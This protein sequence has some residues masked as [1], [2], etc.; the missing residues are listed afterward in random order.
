MP[1]LK[2]DSEGQ[3]LSEYVGREQT[4]EGA[5]MP[6]LSYFVAVKPLTVPY[7]QF[8]VPINVPPSRVGVGEK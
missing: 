8:V 1:L 3:N 4:G 6:V 2:A 5:G 7:D